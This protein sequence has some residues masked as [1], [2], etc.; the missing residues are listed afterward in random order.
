[1]P[2]LTRYLLSP[3]PGLG[4]IFHYAS[5]LAWGR[6]CAERPRI[7][8]P[9]TGA[10]SLDGLV[11]R[12]FYRVIGALARVLFHLSVIGREHVPRAGPAV[13]VANHQ[14]W[15]DPI[16]LALALPRKPAFLAMEELWR[17]P[18]VSFVLRRYPL[19]IP[20]RRGVVDAAALRRSIDVLRQG[21]LLIVFP[22]GGISPDGRLQPFQRGAAMLAARSGAPIVPVALAGTREALPLGR[23]VP[24][25]RPVTIRIGTPFHVRGSSRDDLIRAAEEAAAQIHAMLGDPA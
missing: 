6:K 9:D 19:A 16:L 11:Y 14:S 1:M 10:C 13:V 25:P 3:T 12:S 2:R 22:E 24:R 17:M 21:A 8:R 5:S 18:V 23:I 7:L 15:I 20:I 4:G